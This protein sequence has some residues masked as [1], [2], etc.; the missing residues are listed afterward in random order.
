MD[1]ETKSE[2]GTVDRLKHI[3]GVYSQKQENLYMQR[4]N[5]FGGRITWPQWRRVA[6]LA[7]RYTPGTDLHI[8]T[9]QDIE[10]HN[11]S[12]EDVVA[13][14]DGLAEVGISTHRAGGDSL[15]NITI[16]PGCE[17][18]EGGFD[19]LAL[20]QDVHRQLEKQKCIEEMP[21]KFKISFS[22]CQRAC[23]RPYVSG[24][25]FVAKPDGSL[26][27][28][29]AGSLGAKP[30]LGIE[31]YDNLDAREAPLLCQAALKFFVDH[32]DRE[33]RRRARFRHIRERMGDKAFCAELDNR[34]KKEKEHAPSAD[35]HIAP[36]PNTTCNRRLIAR[37]QL[38]AGNISAEDA[39]LLADAGDAANALLRIDI[40][41]GLQLY[42]A[43]EIQLPHSLKQLQGGPTIVACPGTTTCRNAIT[44]AP[45]IAREIYTALADVDAAELCINISGCQN[46]CVQS[47]VA[48]IGLIGLMRTVDQQ[49][50]EC[51]QVFTEG[52]NGQTDKAAQKGSIL[53]ANRIAQC[54]AEAV[55][56]NPNTKPTTID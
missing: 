27:V 33:N 50:Q 44:N 1:K 17:F 28:I 31:L 40:T 15:R 21:R 47:T 42:A 5:I 24:L 14:Q 4:I 25:G 16:C 41:H 3:M 49:R 52:G 12:A 13:V 38:I 39:L 6:Q 11:L 22:G 43:A 37:L 56:K 34:F 26:T 54:I 2:T 19:L 35:S 7:Q 18:H 8:T 51:Y 20:A 45:A 10:Y 29:G 48:D 23:G 53:P 46:N 30:Q 32:G 9:R 55:K 36:K